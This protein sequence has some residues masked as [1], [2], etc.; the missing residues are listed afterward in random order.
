MS[1]PRSRPPATPP[2]LPPDGATGEWSSATAA[3]RQVSPD[4][5]TVTSSGQ[6]AVG[7][8]GELGIPNPFGRYAVQRLLGRGGM[9]AVFLAH[10]TQLER[11]VALK[12]PT[13][14]GALSPAQKE[15]FL[16]EARSVAALRH[17]HIC[18]V[19]DVDEEQGILYLTTAYI[20][21]HT[22]ATGLKGGPMDPTRAAELIRKV[23][24]GMEEAH[25]R[26][27]IHRDLKP[28]NIMI[29]ADGEPVVMDFGL[30]RKAEDEGEALGDS[31]PPTTATDSGLTQ[32]GSILG[33]PAYMPPEQARGDLAAI[34]P[35]SDVYAL[36]A[37][38]Y[39]CLT[40]RRPFDGPDTASVIQ[41]ILHVPP[42]KPGR[43]V[44][45]LDPALERVCLT[46]LAK[47]PAD[48]Y[49]SM[50]AFAAALKDVIDPELKVVEPPPLPPEARGRRRKPGRHPLKTLGC[51]GLALT[52][53]L[54]ACVGAPTLAIWWLI[55]RASDKFKEINQAQHEADAEWE[56]IR[57]LWQPPPADAGP[58][59]LFPAT[60]AGGYH[61]VRHDQEGA[62][63]ELG[64]TLAGRR[65]VYVG[66]DGEE[67]EV[68]AYRCPDEEAKKV[69][70]RVQAFV[71]S[72]Q[73]GTAVPGPGSKRKQVVYTTSNTANRTFTWGFNDTLGQHQ[74][75]GKLW[76]GH[77]WL[78]W[79]K[80]TAPLKIEYFPSKYLMEV[81]KTA[82]NP[83]KAPDPPKAGRKKK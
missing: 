45:G 43:Y 59:A 15:R 3:D 62:D 57:A 21:G 29:D 37:V 6:P 55:D 28:A 68:R 51:V 48:R 40:G 8:A 46:A 24:L 14:R 47:D 23:A 25:E 11:P 49:P 76:Y 16:R 56:T 20:D 30:A 17:P 34:G 2:P 80:A 31:R 54:A 13:F 12:I 44:P 70:D 69:E 72:V 50:A 19:F 41:K 26:G 9:G 65:A 53:V 74:E 60:L 63:A 77:G 5:P 42:P 36:G 61:R 58:D 38:L 82:G 10:D 75:Y 33:T 83:P 67:C 66:P 32:V 39:E 52:V 22:L 27:T 18:P 71:Q 4:S 7:P 1:D 73:T 81:W 79:F 35:R 78:F 64:I